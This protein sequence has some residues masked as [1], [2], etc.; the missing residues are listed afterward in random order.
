MRGAGTG[1]TGTSDGCTFACTPWTSTAGTFTCRLVSL[2][3]VGGTSIANGAKVGLMARANLASSAA[4]V[5]LD[6]AAGRGAHLMARAVDTLN[7][8]DTHQSP[9]TQ[10]S[11]LFGS[12]FIMSDNSKPAA[13][14]LLRPV[15]L[16]LTLSV[17]TWTAFTSLD[18]VHWTQVG[19]HGVEA[20]GAWVGLAVT[21]HQ[22]GHYVQAVFDHVTGFQPDTFVRIGSV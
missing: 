3:A 13:N 15:W 1:V 19:T 5:F 8:A 17:D 6:V 14:Y 18:G 11:G 10:A 16:R 21:S 22:S 7:I 9:A 20:V 4:T 2:A 12:T